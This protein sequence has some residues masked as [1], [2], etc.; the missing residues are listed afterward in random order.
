LCNDLISKEIKKN[1]PHM[2]CLE[3]TINNDSKSLMEFFKNGNLKKYKKIEIFLYGV[4][5]YVEI[6]SGFKFFLEENQVDITFPKINTIRHL[7]IPEAAVYVFCFQK[8][9]K[10]YLLNCTPPNK[11]NLSLIECLNDNELMVETEILSL[12]FLNNFHVRI[13][14]IRQ[15]N[16]ILNIMKFLMEEESNIKKIKWDNETKILPINEALN[17]HNNSIRERL[18]ILNQK[19]Y[20]E[21]EVGKNANFNKLLKSY[22]NPPSHHLNWVQ[23]EI[24][25]IKNKKVNSIK[26][27][28]VILFF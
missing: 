6:D 11:V 3:H 21:I 27:L 14:T 7:G 9:L 4:F 10:E 24:I 2:K 28:K 26:I 8:I 23:T 15:M 13:S 18:L 12:L 1:I 19:N 22:K 20:N 16:S 25:P 17:Y 5:K